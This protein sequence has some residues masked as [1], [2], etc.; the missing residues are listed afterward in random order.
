MNEQKILEKFHTILKSKGYKGEIISA[1]HIPDILND[2]QKH[3]KSGSIYP[4][5]YD[6]YQSFF[7]FKPDV[8]F[9]DVKSLI[10]VAV[11][12]P[13]F[14]ITF[15]R[16]SKEI[17]LIIPPTYLYGRKIAD[18]TQALLETLFK[19]EGYNLAYA[20]IPVKT[21]A[22]RSGL[23]K[24]GRNNITYIPEMGSFYRLSAYYSDFPYNKSNWHELM[25]MDACKECSACRNACP[26]GAISDDRF[27]LHVER[28]LT[29]HNEQPGDIPFPQWIK[30]QWHNCLVGC[31]YCQ[32][33][34]PVNKKVKNWTE[35]GPTFTNGELSLFLSNTP[36]DKLP[37]E[38]QKKLEENELFE[39][40]EVF[41]R[42][43]Q[44]FL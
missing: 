39:Y 4:N 38:T 27:L 11:P 8:A 25:M 1:T 23:A 28:C 17:S 18:E 29:Y 44:V 9:G 34:C 20:R 15:Q 19:P 33:V 32:K 36:F 30:H 3:H 24:Y 31:L 6:Q 22:V 7:E 16:N 43:I 2:I 5:L 35:L 21:L 12:V 40:L 10:V 42:N 14:K 41:P 37:E 13:Q 26:T